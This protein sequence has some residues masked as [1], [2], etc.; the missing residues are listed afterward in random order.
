MVLGISWV[1]FVRVVLILRKL[2]FLI[3]DNFFFFRNINFCVRRELRTIILISLVRLNL[4]H[5]LNLICLLFGILVLIFVHRF[6]VFHL[7]IIDEVRRDLQFNSLEVI[8]KLV[9]HFRGFIV[10]S[11][12]LL[13]QFVNNSDAIRN[14]FLENGFEN[15]LSYL[16]RN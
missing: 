4:L 8:T 5:C 13:W 14:M 1:I 15:M 11:K 16:F 6:S 12:P 9:D 10:L 3:L 2:D 7:N